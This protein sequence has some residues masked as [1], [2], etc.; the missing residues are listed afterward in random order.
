ME[1]MIAEEV[2]RFLEHLAPL[3]GQP[4][5]HLA[6][7]AGQPP[8]HLA[9]LA[10]RPPSEDLAPLSGR[11][12]SE[13]LAP[14]SGRAPSEHLAP[15]SGRPP[16][17]HLAP[18][19][20]QPLDVEDLL[21]LPILN[22]LC[23]ITMGDRF[24]YTDSRLQGKGLFTMTRKFAPFDSIYMYSSL[25]PPAPAQSHLQMFNMEL[26]L[27]SKSPPPPRIWAH[28][29]GRYWSAKIDDISL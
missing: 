12:P 4:P 10:G 6:P 1:E 8:E 26:D 18:L 15:L 29:R 11:A 20:G 13:H 7:L 19:A 17:E 27:K 3:A 25:L 5:E 21:N 28:I 22:T 9:P 16:S 14:L 23:R 24:E 2:Q